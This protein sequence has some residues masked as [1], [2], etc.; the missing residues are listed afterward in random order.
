MEM[1]FLQVNRVCMWHYSS[2]VSRDES[3]SPS[4]LVEPV[5]LCEQEMAAD[6]TDLHFLDEER[7]FG[8]FSNGCVM[9]FRFRA[10]MQVDFFVFLSQVMTYQTSS[11]S[12]LSLPPPLSLSPSPP[13]SLPQVL[14]VSH[15][16]EGLH[17]WRGGQPAPCTALA[18][19]GTTIVTGGEDGR[20]NIIGAD[21]HYPLRTIGRPP[22]GVQINEMFGEK[23]QQNLKGFIRGGGS[24]LP[25]FSL[26]RNLEI[27]CLL[28]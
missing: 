20:M 2:E 15:V 12:S 11:P 23:K 14:N 17:K 19:S 10:A 3:P 25:Q 5:F 28:Y 9:L 13:L 27:E 26:P 21:D 18:I 7:L 24:P 4:S 1:M 8:S 6:T 22:T 16:W